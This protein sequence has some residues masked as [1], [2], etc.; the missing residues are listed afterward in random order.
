M[1]RCGPFDAAI[2]RRE[3]WTPAVPLPLSDSATRKSRALGAF[4]HALVLTLDLRVP[5]SRQNRP[6]LY[7]SIATYHNEIVE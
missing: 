6:S 5:P 4:N 3:P 7:Y 2:R 1:S